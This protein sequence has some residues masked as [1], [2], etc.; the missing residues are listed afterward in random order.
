MMKKIYKAEAKLEE[1][2]VPVNLCDFATRLLTGVYIKRIEQN[3][4]FKF[5][6]KSDGNYFLNIKAFT[7]LLLEASEKSESIFVE[8]KRGKVI[9]TA[10][11]FSIHSNLELFSILKAYY[12]KEGNK[13]IKIILPT[14][15]TG[16]TEV[17]FKSIWDYIEQPFSEINMWFQ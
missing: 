8:G 3:K 17:L 4:N 6:V 11:S 2:T 10:E 9:I 7:V 16:K 1:G 15:A 14:D 5:N 12:F 13:K